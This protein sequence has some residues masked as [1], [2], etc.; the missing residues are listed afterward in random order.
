[1]PYITTHILRKARQLTLEEMIYGSFESLLNEPDRVAGGGT[2]T[3]HVS[4]IPERLRAQVS[5]SLLTAVLKDFADRHAALYDRPRQELYHTFHIPKKTGGLRQID[6][7][8][9][10]LKAALNELK[11]IFETKF[12]ALHHTSAFAYVKDRSTVDVLKRHQATGAR[13][14][15]KL[16]FS[17]FF[18]STTE[19]FL[20]DQITQ[21][22]PFTEVVRD[23]EGPVALRKCLNLCTLNGGLPQG[24]PISPMLTNLMMIPL[25]HRLAN[26]L[27][28][29]HMTYTRYADDILISCPH[30]FN[31]KKI[32]AR[33]VATLKAFNAPFSIN[34]KKTHY[35]SSSGSNWCLGLMLNG[36]N[37]ITIG[38]KNVDRFKA[39]CHSFICDAQKGTHWELHD[40]QVFSGLIS[41]Y[42][43]VEKDYIEH[44]IR[45]YNEKFNVDLMEMVRKELSGNV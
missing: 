43:M 2:I 25:D 8:N 41:Y 14:F 34:G 30:D 4:Q 20:F 5:P 19:N 12:F 17:G 10:E 32:E 31:Y 37:Q 38:W 13:W 15:L 28:E 33:V 36:R 45:R 22:F 26:G 24:T 40:V 3:R 9:E 27:H 39:M 35:G 16:D 7:P 44:I 11:T 18:P 29:V 23:P 6:A 1:M 42:K 21:I